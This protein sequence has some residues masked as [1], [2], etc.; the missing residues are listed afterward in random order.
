[1]TKIT[2]IL[3][4][5]F[6]TA[7]APHSDSGTGKPLRTVYVQ[8]SSTCDQPKTIFNVGYSSEFNEGE[9]LDFYL[10]QITGNEGCSRAFQGNFTL[11]GG[12]I[13]TRF[14]EEKSLYN[15]CVVSD[16]VWSDSYSYSM[17]G[18]ILTLSNSSCST[19]YEK[20]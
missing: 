9:T 7:C 5:L 18:N 19:Q 11:N 6:L 10:A 12:K 1:M 17:S 3:V 20:Q 4:G 8:K 13:T 16:F 14:T 2:L 15:T